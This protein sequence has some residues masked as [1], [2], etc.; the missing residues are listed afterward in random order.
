MSLAI[1]EIA[2]DAV[3]DC[4]RD[5]DAF[6]HDLAAGTAPLIETQPGTTF[7]NNIFVSRSGSFVF[8]AYSLMERKLVERLR[9]RWKIPSKK[10]GHRFGWAE[11]RNAREAARR[12]VG[13]ALPVAYLE[14]SS[15]LSCRLQVVAFERLNDHRTLLDA[16]I[17]G[18]SVP[19]L[20]ARVEPAIWSLAV[21]GV[22]HVDL[23]CR[24]L[25]IPR[26]IAAP[27]RIIDW[28]Y[29]CFDRQDVL[30]LYAHYLGYLYFGGAR[31]FISESAFD[32]W[33][34]AAIRLRQAVVAAAPSTSAPMQ[35]YD[36]AKKNLHPRDR[37]YHLF[38]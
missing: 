15:F 7:R 29:A 17:A 20:L 19:A 32:E 8:K 11:W 6:L 9:A 14:D 25:L 26:E 21:A 24:N 38:L 34:R 23:N 30:G 28:E 31:K 33:A 16:M 1:V 3:P 2:E 35:H 37:R 22:F 36:H 27:C 5:V 13:I 4:R 12:N 10:F 18:E